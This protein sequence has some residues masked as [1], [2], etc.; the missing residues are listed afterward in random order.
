MALNK[1]LE[2]G[3]AIT[4]AAPAAANGGIG[5]LA[6]DPLLVGSTVVGGLLGGMAGVAQ[7]S[8]TPPTRVA[9]GFIS[10][11]FEGAYFLTVTAKSSLSPSTGKAIN[12]GDK[13]FVDGGTLDTVTG[14]TYGFTLDANTGGAYFGNALDALASG[15]T[16]VIRVRLKVTG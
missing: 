8:Y 9:D 10:I 1:A 7:T 12:P 4:M 11:D 6:G 3:N 2:R 5:P 16:G 15:A 14:M 13:V